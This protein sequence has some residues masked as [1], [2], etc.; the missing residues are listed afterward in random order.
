MFAAC[1]GDAK[2]PLAWNRAIRPEAA[3]VAAG[4]CFA[5][6]GLETDVESEVV[7]VGD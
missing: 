2:I 3:L 1:P 7:V 5:C 6:L 4:D